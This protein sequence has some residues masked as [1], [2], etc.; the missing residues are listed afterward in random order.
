MRPELGRL[1]QAQLS[2]LATQTPPPLLPLHPQPLLCSV[3]FA[4]G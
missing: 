4:R 1:Q 3:V 2:L